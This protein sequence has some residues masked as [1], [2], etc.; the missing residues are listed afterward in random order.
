MK[1]V[2]SSSQ[3]TGIIHFHPMK[4]LLKLSALLTLALSSLFISSCANSGFSSAGNLG[5]HPDPAIRKA[6]IDT[7]PRGDFFYGRRYYVQKTRFWGYVRKPGQPWDYSKMVLMDESSQTVPDR[8][9]E[10][11]PSGAHYGYD[12]NYEYRITGNYTGRKGYDPNSN[13]F[14]PVF[15]PTSFTLL[16]KKPGWIFTPSDYYNPLY[17]SLRPR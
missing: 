6:Q 5:S 4:K 11:G 3:L 8:L 9:P 10:D 14:L 16:N 7:E 1:L 13:S 12:Q 2:N 15:R 17:I